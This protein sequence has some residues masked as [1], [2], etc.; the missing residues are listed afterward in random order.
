MDVGVGVASRDGIRLA[1]RGEAL[2]PQLPV[3]RWCPRVAGRME[4]DREC[5][6]PLA[7]ACAP[8]RPGRWWRGAGSHPVVRVLVAVEA[9]D[10]VGN[11][12]C[13]T[14]LPGSGPGRSG[15]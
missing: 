4:V 2:E 15:A 13:S 9:T 1:L 6:L 12:H 11:R 5:R 10:G 14:C 3:I 8:A 7:L